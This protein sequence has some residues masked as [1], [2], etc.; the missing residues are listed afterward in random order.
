[1]KANGP[2]EKNEAARWSFKYLNIFNKFY[3]FEKTTVSIEYQIYKSTSW[4]KATVGDKVM[5]EQGTK[6]ESLGIDSYAYA[7]KSKNKYFKHLITV[8]HIHREIFR[9]VYFFI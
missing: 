8:G 4:S 5:K 2:D 9:H 6:K 1:M 7:V 3:S